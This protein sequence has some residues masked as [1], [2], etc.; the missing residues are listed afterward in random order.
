MTSST[1]RQHPALLVCQFQAKQWN[2]LAFD[3]RTGTGKLSRA[4]IVNTLRGDIEGEGVLEYLLSYPNEAGAAVEFIGYERLV[5]SVQGRVGSMVVE[6]RGTFSPV[7]GVHGTL[8]VR[9]GSGTGAWAGLRGAGT[10]RAKAGEH[11]GEY[12]LQ[13]GPTA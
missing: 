7:D 8:V 9:P 6:H 3:E 1:T 4:S 2:E 11:G 13:T 10:I 12:R 5:G